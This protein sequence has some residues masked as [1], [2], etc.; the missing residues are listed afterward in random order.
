MI[1][2]AAEAKVNGLKVSAKHVASAFTAVLL[3]VSFSPGGEA[4]DSSAVERG[5]ALH[6][7]RQYAAALEE[8]NRAIASDPQDARAYRARGETYRALSLWSRSLD[9]LTRSIQL[10][11]K[12][13]ASYLLRAD[14]YKNLGQFEKA[15][16]DIARGQKLDPADAMSFTTAGEVYCA[17]GEYAKSIEQFDKAIRLQPHDPWHYWCRAK[18]HTAQGKFDLAV[19]D[20]NRAL[21]V[22]PC[23]SRDVQAQ[24]RAY[25]G[26]VYMYQKRHAD[27]LREAD[28]AIALNAQSSEAYSLR[29]HVYECRGDFKRAIECYTKMISLAPTQP[30]NYLSRSDAYR[31]CGQLANALADLDQ[32]LKLS[33]DLKSAVLLRRAQILRQQGQFANALSLLNTAIK[34]DPQSGDL[35][36]ER[37]S[38]YCQN[39][40]QLERALAD[41]KAAARLAKDRASALYL[42]AECQLQLG[43]LDDALRT[44]NESIALFPTEIVYRLRALIQKERRQYT[45]AI[46][47]CSKAIELAPSQMNYRTR[48]SLYHM[49]GQNDRALRDLEAAFKFG[50]TVDEYYLRGVIRSERHDERNAISDFAS[51]IKLEP[52][53]YGLY[54]ARA[55]NF[56]KL[57]DYTRAAE[58][59]AAAAKIAPNSQEVQ[60]MRRELN[61]SRKWRTDL[62]ASEKPRKLRESEIAL[63]SLNRAIKEYPGDATLYVRRARTYDTMLE[64]E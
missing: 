12:N 3:S 28:A 64:Y 51:A 62:D 39:L 41:F 37:G 33:A 61:S 24:M 31:A 21:D 19:L 4:N 46:A 52:R 1:K 5:L 59:I 26:L 22:K 57:R 7:K 9:D 43:R 38:L 60:A 25:R 34:N 23:P 32:A 45:N 13:P 16:A 40:K 63:D 49:I 30:L 2:E 10:D 50:P 27:A 35:L 47:D 6:N 56:I 17:L 15:L 44:V 8:F 20:M 55:S 58:D 36:I 54:L 48:A 42:Q 53:K 11:G 18:T 29:G 14:S